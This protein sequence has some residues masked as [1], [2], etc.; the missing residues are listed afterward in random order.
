[1]IFGMNLIFCMWSG[2]HKYIYMIQFIHIGVVRHTWVCQKYFSILNTQYIK[3]ELDYHGAYMDRHPQ[4]E[5]IPASIYL[6]KV[7]NGSTRAGCEICSKLSTKT[8]E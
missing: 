1:M 8:P 2:I 3:T 5:Q 6:L 7:N 4:K